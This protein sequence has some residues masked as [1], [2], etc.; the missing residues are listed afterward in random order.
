MEGGVRIDITLKLFADLRK[1][2]EDGVI[3]L[4]L[5]GN[6]AIK[7]LLDTLK[8]DPFL[9]DKLFENNDIR[10]VFIVLV[11]GRRIDNLD[12]LETP[13]SDGDVVS[14]FPPVAGG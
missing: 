14:I 8:G 4:A 2:G 9:S 5:G 10:K 7:E 12:G 6:A 11:N 1:A 13:L 3:T